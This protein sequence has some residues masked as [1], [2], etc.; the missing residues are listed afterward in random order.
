MKTKRIILSALKSLGKNK[1]RTFLMMIG[2]IIGIIA[3]TLIV[4]VGFGAK[5]Q[6][7]E[8]V[9]KFGTHSL[10]VFAGGGTQMS[11]ISATQG[12]TN[13]KPEDVEYLEREIPE[14]KS[15]APLNR[16][17]NMDIKYFE[18]S[19]NATVFGITPSWAPVWDWDVSEGDFINDE[20]MKSLNRICLI[21]PTVQKELFGDNYPIGEMIRIGNIQFEVKGILEPKGT[22]P[23]GGAVSYTHLDVYKRQN[24]TISRNNSTI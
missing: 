5:D 9:N 20:D 12:T 1:L 3:L 8:R 15:L 21:G 10:L 24:K 17:A 6:V 11:Q 23:R 16:Q 2:I 14:I 7:M 18:R 22:S 4:S 19:T 13:L